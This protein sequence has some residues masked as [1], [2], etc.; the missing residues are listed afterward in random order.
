MIAIALT[1]NADGTFSALEQVAPATRPAGA[2]P[3]PGCAT[4]DTYA[5]VY[6][7][8]E[9]DGTSTVVTWTYG[10][11]TVNA[12]EGC[13][14]ASLDRAGTTAT[15]DAIASYTAQNILPPA[16][17]AF[18]ETPTTLVLTPGFGTSTTFSKSH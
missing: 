16:T 5:G 14:D 7:V 13:D 17:E 9:T 12:V 3:A 11:G 15:R 4:N 10:T 6:D 8:A 2:A 1:F 18:T